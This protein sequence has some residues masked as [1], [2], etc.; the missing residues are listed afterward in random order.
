[1]WIN[2]VLLNVLLWSIFRQVNEVRDGCL[3]GPMLV[4]AAVRAWTDA[5]FIKVEG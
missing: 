5:I 3:F 1:M 2:K 4:L